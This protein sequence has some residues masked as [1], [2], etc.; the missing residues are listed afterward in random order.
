MPFDL[1]EQTVSALASTHVLSQRSPEKIFE[2]INLALKEL[3]LIKPD[4]PVVLIAG[5]NGKGSVA[6]GLSACLINS[7]KKV[8]L[9]T[10]PHLCF[11]NERI[12]INNVPVFDQ[13]LL[14]ILEEEKIKNIC[15]KYELN[16]FQISFVLALKSFEKNNLDIAILE[17]GLGG[18][19]DPVNALEPCLSII[20]SISKDHM[21]I[22]GNSLEEIA[23]QKLGIVRKNIPLIYAD[24]NPQEIIIKNTLASETKIYGRDFDYP[25]DWP[26]PKM[27]RENAAAVIAALEYL[28]GADLVFARWINVINLIP[29]ISAPGRLV[30]LEKD[31]HKILIDVAHNEDSC[32]RLLG[33]IQEKLKQSCARPK[34]FG[35]FTAKPNKDLRAMVSVMSPVIDHWYCVGLENNP[36]WLEFGDLNLHHCAALN[37]AYEEA[38]QNLAPGDWIICFGSFSVASYV[39]QKLG[40]FKHGDVVFV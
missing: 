26:E 36:V 25:S 5:T 24:R 20:T 7:G 29:N 35:V 22:L 8:G 32:R 40:V 37:Q 33:F 10:S 30:W 15:L 6:H 13:D 38:K 2:R 17:I 16:Y 11:F 31:D 4:Y 19:F 3:N 12:R 39:L 14:E 9:F 18:R 1:L 34:I 21:E 28:V 23:W 27:A